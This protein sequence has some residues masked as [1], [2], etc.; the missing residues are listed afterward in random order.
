MKRATPQTDVAV[1]RA[2]SFNAKAVLD[3]NW[4]ERILD[5][6]A[7][8]GFFWF[9]SSAGHISRPVPGRTGPYAHRTRRGLRPRRNDSER[10]A[11]R[12]A[13]ASSLDG[14]EVVL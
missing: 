12:G 7:P 14:S 10:R 2:S 3:Y 11:Q 9:R 4:H 8:Q 1:S 13:P 5:E 6:A